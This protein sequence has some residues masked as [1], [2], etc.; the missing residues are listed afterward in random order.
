[1]KNRNCSKYS[2]P[3]ASVKRETGIIYQAFRQKLTKL[4]IKCVKLQRGKRG[5]RFN[6]ANGGGTGVKANFR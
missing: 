1:M 6:E 2:G 3:V 4:K 5:T